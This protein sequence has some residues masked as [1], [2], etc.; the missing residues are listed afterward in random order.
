MGRWWLWWVLAPTVVARHRDL[1]W[2]FRDGCDLPVVDAGGLEPDLFHEALVRTGIPALLVNVSGLRDWPASKEWTWETLRDAFR[3]VP[4]RVGM[5]PYPEIRMSIDA[6]LN[7]AMARS[8]RGEEV[9]NVFQYGRV[10]SSWTQWAHK[11]ECIPRL[12]LLRTDG[13]PFHED[14]DTACKLLAKVR[15][16]D[17]LVGPGSAETR[18]PNNITHSG[19]LVGFTGS[20][21]DFH[22]HEAA[23]NV[24]FDGRKEWFV[25]MQHKHYDAGVAN[26]HLPVEG[27]LF[28]A[29]KA[30]AD[31]PVCLAQLRQQEFNKAGTASRNVPMSLDEANTWHLGAFA[32]RIRTAVVNEELTD[33]RSVLLHCDQRA[34][35]IMFVPTD[36]QHAA[37]NL[38][39]TVAMQMQWDAHLYATR[40][41]RAEVLHHL[42]QDPD[43]SQRDSDVVGKEEF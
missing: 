41:H 11:V 16:P 2:M 17:F 13:A 28:C 12:S 34:G 38:K 32:R 29:Q 39:P 22:R 43:P 30:Q 25:K 6:Y 26:G 35:E 24:I 20:G 23:I 9:P 37:R 10:P 27:S 3:D 7:L 19:V 14:L 33:G 31:D 40:S 21:F 42:V 15:V 5:G 1:I 4:L 8:T 36:M 18:N